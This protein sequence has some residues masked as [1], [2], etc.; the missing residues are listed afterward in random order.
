MFKRSQTQHNK[1]P[2]LNDSPRKPSVLARAK[3]V[4]SSEKA[5]EKK[6]KWGKRRGGDGYITKAKAAE[7]PAKQVDEDP[8]ETQEEI[9]IKAEE[10]D[11]PQRIAESAEAPRPDDEEA[12]L[13]STLGKV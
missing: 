4:F 8:E 10:G 9:E 7:K 13:Y 5:A 2:P 3:G 1:R 11:A 6:E 12:E